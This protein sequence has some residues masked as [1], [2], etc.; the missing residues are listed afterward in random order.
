M[1]CVNGER[2]MAM[3]HVQEK[4]PKT[5]KILAIRVDNTMCPIRFVRDSAIDV[6][7]I[8]RPS[9]FDCSEGEPG[10]QIGN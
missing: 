3:L 10:V 5:C 4:E 8:C 2:I 9:P 1:R 7:E 6:L